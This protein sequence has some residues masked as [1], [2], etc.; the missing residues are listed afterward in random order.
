MR[1]VCCLHFLHPI[2]ASCLLPPLPAS[3]LCFLFAASTSCI[4]SM[5]PVCCLHF[6]HRIYASCL[7]PPLPASYLCFLF[8]ASTSCILSMLPVCCLH[9][10]HL[11]YASCLLPPLPASCLCFLFAASTSCMLSMLPVCWLH[12]LHRIYASCLQCRLPVLRRHPDSGLNVLVLSDTSHLWPVLICPVSGLRLRE[13]SKC[14]FPLTQ[15]QRV[16][17]PAG[18]LRKPSPGC[19]GSGRGVGGGEDRQLPCHFPAVPLPQ[20][21]RVLTKQLHVWSTVRLPG[22][23]APWNSSEFTSW[24]VPVCT[25]KGFGLRPTLV[26]SPK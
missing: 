1:P 10:L 20:L 16:E 4:L 18:R 23:S 15:S 14:F 21:P 3:Y 2:Y 12:F 6:L 24:R 7:L 17:I 13:G 9:F 19:T 22:I 26:L 25:T 11:I 8:A 5:L